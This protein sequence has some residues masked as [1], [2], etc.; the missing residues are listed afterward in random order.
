MQNDT[1]IFLAVSP[2]AFARL[3]ETKQLGIEEFRCLD[4]HT[5]RQV[6]SIYLKRLRK[7]MGAHRQ[8]Q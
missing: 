8:L 4:G 3:L 1:P 5:K 2:D 7:K 6:K